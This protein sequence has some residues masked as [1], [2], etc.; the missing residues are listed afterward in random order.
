MRYVQQAGGAL[1]AAAFALSAT[2]TFP[3]GTPGPNAAPNPYRLDEG[4]AKLPPGRNWGA[5]FGASVDRSDG[6]SMWAFD[7]CEQQTLCGDSH[8]PPIFHFDATGK[9][10]A[11]FG[12]TC[13]LL[14][15]PVCRPVRECL[16]D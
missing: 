16:G 12:A 10:I 14:R 5:T 1:I 9:V 8:L 13:S 15:R 11:N 6:R 7:R 2:R 3:Q 4:W